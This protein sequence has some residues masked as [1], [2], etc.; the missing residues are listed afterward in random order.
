MR[1]GPNE[2]SFDLR[3]SLLPGKEPVLFGLGFG[4][5]GGVTLVDAKTM[6]AISK[7]R[8]RH[9]QRPI[10]NHFLR[11]LAAASASTNRLPSFGSR[12]SPLIKRL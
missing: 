4:Q 5:G 12:F 10:A 8:I 9:I 11:L 1:L 2:G 7:T 6:T 3:W